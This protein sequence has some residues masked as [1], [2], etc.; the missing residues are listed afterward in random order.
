MGVIDTKNFNDTEKYTLFNFLALNYSSIGNHEKSVEYFQ[1]ILALSPYIPAFAEVQTYK[2][3][4]QAYYQLGDR[5]NALI[6]FVRWVDYQVNIPSVDYSFGSLLFEE[7]G[8]L[9]RAIAN[10][11]RALE[12]KTTPISKDDYQH[13]IDLYEINNDFESAQVIRELQNK[14]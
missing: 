14:I 8:D 11:A 5:K 4:S 7:T 12:F 3:I 13:L 10:Y 2:L 9:R 1:K 6:F